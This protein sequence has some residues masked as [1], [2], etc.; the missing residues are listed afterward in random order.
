MSDEIQAVTAVEAQGVA[1][2]L[3]EA[4][5]AVGPG[6]PALRGWRCGSC[7]RLAFGV[8]R[9]CPTCG[10]RGGRETRLERTARL[11]T[12]TRVLGKTEYIIGYG[13]VG[14]GEDEQEVRVFAPIDVPDEGRLRPGQ[15]VDIR[16]RTGIIVWG[17]ERLHHYFAP[18]GADG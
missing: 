6:G 13:L 2:V 18:G 8:K 7:G 15:P 1:A 12:W 14:D 17:D 16:F 4:L 3:D 10:A 9:I 11:E 5:I